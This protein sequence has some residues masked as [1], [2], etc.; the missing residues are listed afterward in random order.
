[1]SEEKK[2][3]L[4]AG[5]E[6]MIEETKVDRSAEYKEFAKN[7][8]Q[9]LYYF[10]NDNPFIGGILQEMNFKPIYDLPSAAL[11]YDKKRQSFE[12]MI[13]PEF[14]NSM[15]LEHRTGVLHHEV[16]HF[17][18]THVFRF[19]ME[20]MADE[21]KKRQNI[22]CDMAINQYIKSLPDGCI[23]VKFFKTDDGKDFPKYAT[24]EVYLQLL[25][26][27]PEAMKNAIQAMKDAGIQIKEGPGGNGVLDE[28][29]WDALSEEEKKQMAEEMKKIVK[30]T[31]EKTSYD[32]S[33]LPDSI[34][35]LIEEIDTFLRK[36]NYKQILQQAI[37]KSV[38]F[39]DRT[40]T[41]KRPN[42]RYGVVAQGTTLGKLPQLNIYIDTSGSISVKEMNEFL[43]ILN[44]FL[45]AGTRK[46]QL[47]LWHTSLYKKRLYKMNG[48][49][50][51]DEIESGGTDMTD[52][53]EDINKSAPDLSI[54]LT[55]GYY[56]TEVQ[57]KNDTIIIISESGGMDHPLK[58]NKKVKTLGMSGLRQS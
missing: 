34:K 4:P 24:A 28:H 44:G 48:K 18:N 43:T 36:M 33:A 2:S 26:D 15:S 55:D 46:C 30:R 35:D 54:I 49:L 51:Q 27:N 9:S 42:K 52:V 12:I 17:T 11:C 14:F 29:M 41:W 45:K 56:S 57:P 38:S 23:D 7:L 50:K 22:A 25:K 13:N 21:D 10:T 39:T 53:C 3:N 37:K 8:Q 58:R 1:M 40:S 32:K 6:K 20:N 5:L 31:M 19:G 47:G 16:L